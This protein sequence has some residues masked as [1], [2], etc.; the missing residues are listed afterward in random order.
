MSKNVFLI[1]DSIRIWYQRFLLEFLPEGW[2]VDGPDENCKDSENILESLDHWVG[3]KEPDYLLVNCGLH[4]IRFCPNEKKLQTNPKVFEKNLEEI[5]F[6]LKKLQ[7]TNVFWKTITPI[8]QEQ[9]NSLRK[10]SSPYQRFE[11][12]LIRYNNI[13]ISVAKRISIPIIDLSDKN[14][15]EKLRSEIID[16]VHF[17]E[18][19]YKIIAEKIAQH[20]K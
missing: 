5:F 18:N 11:K 6:K 19:G 20:L 12:D 16:G 8:N 4:D 9:Y 3:D 15:T 14:L 1:G 17:T 10:D 7:N 13:A 2:T